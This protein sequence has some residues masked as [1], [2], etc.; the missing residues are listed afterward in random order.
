MSHKPDQPRPGSGVRQGRLPCACDGRAEAEYPRG[1]QCQGRGNRSHRAGP[2][3]Q[4]SPKEQA[5]G[6]RRDERA[7]PGSATP[8]PPKHVMSPA[9]A[10]QSVSDAGDQ[11]HDRGVPPWNAREAATT[12]QPGAAKAFPLPTRSNASPSGICSAKAQKLYSSISSVMISDK[13]MFFVCRPYT[14]ERSH[15]SWIFGTSLIRRR[16]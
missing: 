1:G 4:Q 11:A 14:V 3:A 12:R 6:P 15:T 5:E 13:D 16:V 8:A 7:Q 10:K 2:T 9:D